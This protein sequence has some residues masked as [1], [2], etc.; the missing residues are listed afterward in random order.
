MELLLLAMDPAWLEKLSAE[1]GARGRFE[2]AP[3]FHFADPLLKMLVE[4]LVA[5]FDAPGTPDVLYAESLVQ[6]AAAVVV[7]ISGGAGRTEVREGGLSPRRLAEALDFIHANLA[8]RIGLE[9]LAAVAGVSASHFTRAFRASVGESPH[10]YVMQQRLDRARRA[11][12]STD[13]PIT[14]IALECG[15]ADRSHLTR[16]MRRHLG[17]TPRL[18]REGHERA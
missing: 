6:A 5:E 3:R 7:R 17:A 1:D 8:S 4:R 11:L 12:L 9:E 18:L 2:L 10:R 15:F 13:K 14:E 16:M